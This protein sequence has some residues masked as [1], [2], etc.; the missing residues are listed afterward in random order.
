MAAPL[1]FLSAGGSG[2][3]LVPGPDLDN[4]CWMVRIVADP[5]AVEAA[6]GFVF[7][8][9]LGDDLIHLDHGGDALGHG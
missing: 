5:A 2:G 3:V 1:M 7:G 8:V 4:G 6:V 9:G